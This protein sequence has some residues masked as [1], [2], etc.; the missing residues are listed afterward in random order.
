MNEKKKSFTAFQALILYLKIPNNSGRT[1]IG[2]LELW[3]LVNRTVLPCFL[4]KVYIS[5]MFPLINGWVQC[6]RCF[7][8]MNTIV[9]SL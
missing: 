1:K 3:G 2:E 6:N 7:N 9:Y 8:D 4:N 5:Y